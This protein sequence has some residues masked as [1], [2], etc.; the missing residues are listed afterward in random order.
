MMDGKYTYKNGDEVPLKEYRG[1]AGGL[2]EFGPTLAKKIYP[3]KPLQ[4]DSYVR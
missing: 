1:F 3:A 4:I 2:I